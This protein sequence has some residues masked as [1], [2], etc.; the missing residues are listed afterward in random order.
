MASAAEVSAR[1]EGTSPYQPRAERPRPVMAVVGENNETELTDFVVFYAVLARSGVADVLSVATQPGILKLRPAVQVQ[2]QATTAGFDE[3]HPAGADY[4]IVRAVN[5]SDD[6]ALLA[7]I[8]A[9]AANGAT[10]VSVCDGALVM[11]NTRLMR[12]HRATGH[13]PMGDTDTAGEVVPRHAL[14]DEH[15]LRRRPSHRLQRRHQRVD[16]DRVRPGGS[17]RGP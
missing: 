15:A 5:K 6:G 7:R 8:T 1:V 4:V 17:H 16:P 13:R 14:G 3:L 10:I 11:A 2:P 9:Q 12:G